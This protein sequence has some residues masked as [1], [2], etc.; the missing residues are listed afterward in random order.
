MEGFKRI[1][2]HTRYRL[3][4]GTIVPGVTTVLGVLNKPAL[5]K[6]ANNLGLQGI[7]STKYVDATAQAGTLAHYL[8]ECELT[9]ETPDL[10][11]FSQ[12]QITLAQHSLD[13][14]TVWRKENKIRPKLIASEVP[15]VSEAH[16]YGG[17]IDI[18][19]KLKG[20][21]ELI[22]VKTAK[23]IYPEH[24]HQ[25]AAYWYLAEANGYTI[26]NTR[27]LRLGRTPDEGYDE[28]HVSLAEIEKH[29]ELFQH[30]LEVYRLQKELR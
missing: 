16:R 2:A 28:K 26:H 10:A 6:W 11:P 4:D 9:G 20:K 17:T 21:T 27:I 30:C 29:W 7:D 23:A 18:I 8:I 14:W 22:D 25:L 13:K 1:K 5:V 15:L 19:A 12:E 3:E 24:I